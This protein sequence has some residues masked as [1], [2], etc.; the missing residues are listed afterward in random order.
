MES[1]KILILLAIAL[2]IYIIYV[3]SKK[4]D[5]KYNKKLK[6]SE[7]Q[8]VGKITRINLNERGRTWYYIEFEKDGMTHTAQTSSLKK[9]PDDI[10]IGDEVNIKYHFTKGGK[11]ALCRI[12]DDGFESVVNYDDIEK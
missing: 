2:I 12:I 7:I 9:V 6:E 11:R 4:S 3:I 1:M 5:E 10:Q 8:S